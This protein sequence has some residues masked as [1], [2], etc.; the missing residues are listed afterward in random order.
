MIH[1]GL[2]YID[3]DGSIAF[4]PELIEHA[5]VQRGGSMYGVYYPRP[6]PQTIALMQREGEYK[7]VR[8]QHDLILTPIPVRRWPQSARITLFIRHQP[9]K[10]REVS[11]FLAERGVSIVQSESVR[12]AYRYEV[13]SFYVVIDEKEPSYRETRTDFQIN[14]KYYKDTKT[15]L[16]EILK[17]LRQRFGPDG[18]NVLFYDDKDDDLKREKAVEGRISTALHYFHYIS[19]LGWRKR[20]VQLPNASPWWVYRFF[21]FRY[22]GAGVMKPVPPEP[23][24]TIL[25]AEGHRTKKEP[26]EEAVLGTE[27]MQL[28]PSVAY[29]SL[30]TRYLHLRVAVIPEHLRKQF[31]ELSISY[32]RIGRPENSRGL[33]HFVTERLPAHYNIWNSIHRTLQSS[34]ESETGQIVMLIEDQGAYSKDARTGL[35]RDESTCVCCAEAW[36]RDL[37]GQHQLPG[38]GIS[39]ESIQGDADSS[40]G[41]PSRDEPAPRADAP[42]PPPEGSGPRPEERSRRGALIEFDKPIVRAVTK[43]RV[44]RKLEFQRAERGGPQVFLSYSEKDVKMATQVQKALEDAGLEVYFASREKEGGAEF[45]DE[46]RSRILS[47]RELWLV[48]TKHSLKSEWVQTEW[49]AAW[50]LE[51]RIVPIVNTDMDPKDLPERLLRRHLVPIHDLEPY[52]RQAA[53]RLDASQLG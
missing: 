21:E 38:L 27:P 51:K 19:T 52:V 49:G 46:I 29:A 41:T 22:A 23:F 8:M 32:R 36:V 30:D 12:A 18:D 25:K 2:S 26:Y 7:D 35:H 10:I 20:G 53:I 33:V 40:K 37:E 6:H 11:R 3:D 50:V 14:G 42:P 9:E 17:E 45:S 34:V 31:F 28:L 15:R 1:G 13:W 39:G 5:L 16:D 48:C 47:C 44:R 43:R 24:P 4:P